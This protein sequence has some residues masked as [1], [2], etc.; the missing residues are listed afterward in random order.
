MRA[1]SNNKQRAAQRALQDTIENIVRYGHRP[2][3]RAERRA[4]RNVDYG[5]YLKALAREIKEVT[6]Q[7]M[8]A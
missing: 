4:E 6:G 2:H 3:N 1:P 7:P 5:D 8:R